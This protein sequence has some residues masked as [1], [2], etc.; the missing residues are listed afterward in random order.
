M[1]GCIF[2]GTSPTTNAHVFRKGWIDRLMPRSGS[3][4]HRRG[5]EIDGRSW[6]KDSMDLKVNVACKDCNSGWMDRLDHAAED[7]FLT[8]AALGFDV[9]ISSMADQKMLARWGLLIATLLDQTNRRPVLPRRVHTA[10]RGGEVPEDATVWIF[11]TEPPDGRDIVWTAMR[12]LTI[13]ALRPTGIADVLD[14]YFATFCV[15][16]LVFHIAQPTE[17]TLSG[18]KIWKPG[19]RSA[20]VSVTVWPT[21]LTP[22]IWPT[23]HALGWDDALDFPDLFQRQYSSPA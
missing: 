15:A 9:K 22:L 1:A 21:P 8:H 5:A 2:C 13:T 23:P 6:I 12:H 20:G 11:R 17:E 3:F 7:A 4:R 16:Q 10:V 14:V 18:I 19:T